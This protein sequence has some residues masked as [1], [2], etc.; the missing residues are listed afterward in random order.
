MGN[1]IQEIEQA[2][3]QDGPNPALVDMPRLE[4]LSE[5]MTE[6]GT[7]MALA[8]AILILGLFAARLVYKGLRKGLLRLMPK[9]KFVTVFCNIVYLSM[10]TI[11]VAAAAVEFGAHP[12]NMLR[13]ITIV[14]LVAIG[15]FGFLRPF[16]PSL[17]FKV[18]N[19]VKVGDLLGKVEAVTFLNTRLMT[20]DGKTFFVPNRQILN[21]IIINYHFTQTR[22]L[23]I[24]IGICYDQ[25][26]LKAKRV[27]ESLMTEDPRI[28]TKPGPTV[29]VL[30]LASSSVD[31]GGR[32]WVDNKDHWVARCDLLE[33][34]K[35][36]FDSEGIEFAFPQLELHYRPDRTR[37]ENNEVPD[38]STVLK[39]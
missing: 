27:L 18:G 15:L 29:Y 20:F 30:N 35:L 6:H 16:L 9:A 10:V 4:R 26:L 31:L 32:C 25:D 38:L 34:V 19:T 21:D 23:K 37:L 24:D 12:V 28:K 2:L 11:V 5:A 13:L 33:K 39:H 7:E 3:T 1:E 8:L 14:A 22:R 36:R 17:P